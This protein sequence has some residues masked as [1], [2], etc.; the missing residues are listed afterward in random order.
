M[1]AQSAAEPRPRER[2]SRT[3]RIPSWIA[4]P[5]AVVGILIPSI[6]TRG[7]VL[8]A[9]EAHST[10]LASFT[11]TTCL[12]LVLLAIVLGVRAPH[13]SP[14]RVGFWIGALYLGIPVVIA[15]LSGLFGH[16]F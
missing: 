11:E 10:S 7:G 9:I 13:R 2:P 12:A 5:C 15:A 6:Q 16:F 8:G 14:G 4:L 1:T 3:T